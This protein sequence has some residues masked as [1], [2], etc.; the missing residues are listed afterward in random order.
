MGLRHEAE[1]LGAPSTSLRARTACLALQG[2]AAGPTRTEARER[3]SGSRKLSHHP[4]PNLE[5]ESRCSARW[6]PWHTEPQTPAE[7]SLSSLCKVVCLLSPSPLLLGLLTGWREVRWERTEASRRNWRR[8]RTSVVETAWE[9]GAASFTH[10]DVPLNNLTLLPKD[11]KEPWL[12][13]GTADK[14]SCSVGGTGECR[15]MGLP[16][17]ALP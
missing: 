7:R 1:V 2:P 4:Q 15:G 6:K 17:G 12:G 13:G 10:L 9:T 3:G 8:G 16:C 11:L 14:L 5:V